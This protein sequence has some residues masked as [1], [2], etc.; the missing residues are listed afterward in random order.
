MELLCFFLLTV[1]MFILVWRV[2]TGK[3][4]VALAIPFA[5]AALLN[6][7]LELYSQAAWRILY[8]PSPYT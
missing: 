3:N 5:G 4:A 8:L 2:A 1:S 7:A 6:F